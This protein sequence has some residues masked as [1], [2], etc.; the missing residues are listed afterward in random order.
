MVGVEPTSTINRTDSE[1]EGGNPCDEM[2]SQGHVV[3]GYLSEVGNISKVL[4]VPV[5]TT[6]SHRRA[7]CAS[8]EIHGDNHQKPFRFDYHFSNI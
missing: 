3:T 2:V 1:K 8:N 4:L 7:G 5:S 6:G